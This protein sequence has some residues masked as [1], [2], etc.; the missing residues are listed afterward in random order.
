MP[1]HIP[2]RVN[3]DVPGMISQLN[4]SY[5]HLV[6]LSAEFAETVDGWRRDGKLDPEADPTLR[7]HY[8]TFHQAVEDAIRATSCWRSSWEPVD[9][10]VD[11]DVHLIADHA[12]HVY[13]IGARDLVA[14]Q[15]RV[16]EL[17]GTGKLDTETHENFQWGHCLDLGENLYYDTV[18]LVCGRTGSGWDEHTYSDGRA[19][20]TEIRPT[21][22][23]ELEQKWPYNDGMC[24]DGPI[25]EYPW[26][27]VSY[28]APV[29][30]PHP[31][32]GTVGSIEIDLDALVAK[33]EKARSWITEENQ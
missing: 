13:A 28:V 10:E 33:V 22:W 6:R 7:E 4:D 1:R 32:I 15:Y 12:K 27:S 29:L 20:T 25:S 23:L 31:G 17:A 14:L 30:D 11:P 9:G 18:D 21:N 19:V 24:G 8:A 16:A 26:F 5:S 3:P 2:P